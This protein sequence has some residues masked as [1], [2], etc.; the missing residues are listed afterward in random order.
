V[1]AHEIDLQFANLITD[2]VYI[3]KLPNARSD[4]VRNLILPDEPIDDGAST[5]D[6]LPGIG[7]EKDGAT[8]IWLRYFAHGFE[9]EIVSVDVEG[10][11]G[12]SQFSVLICTDIPD[13]IRLADVRTLR[14][15][16]ST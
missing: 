6:S 1:R 16:T 11:Q 3:T 15:R 13:D 2:D 5:V 9:R 12:S 4:R 7:R 8:S 10:L 14:I